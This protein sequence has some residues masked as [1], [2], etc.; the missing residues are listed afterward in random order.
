VRARRIRL[1]VL[2]IS[3]Q[4]GQPV[5]PK[6]FIRQAVPYGGLKMGFQDDFR[7]TAHTLD[8]NEKS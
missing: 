2:L 8:Q 6:P 3:S 1:S 4:D 5:L 7:R